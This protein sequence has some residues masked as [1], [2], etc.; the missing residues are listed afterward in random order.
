VGARAPG[1]CA[2]ASAAQR[3]IACGAIAGAAL[4]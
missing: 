4:K 1:C 2:A 3:D